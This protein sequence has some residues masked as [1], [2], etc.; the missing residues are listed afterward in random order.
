MH[1]DSLAAWLLTMGTC[2]PSILPELF[3]CDSSVQGLA[4]P[5]SLA[6][7]FS[8]LSGRLT[9]CPPLHANR[10]PVAHLCLQ[11]HRGRRGRP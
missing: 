4:S 5:L 9:P 10:L 2:V 8:G 6:D 3:E 1:R 11:E 7:L